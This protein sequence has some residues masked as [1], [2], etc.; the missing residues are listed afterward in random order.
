MEEKKLT[1]QESLEVIATMIN[2]TRE[3][4]FGNGNILL[5]WGLLV[6]ATA[7]LVWISLAATRMHVWHL[8]W[9]AIPA[10]GCPA[11]AVMS[12]N[13]LRKEGVKTYSD[14]IVSKLW[15]ITGISAIDIALVCLGFQLI[16]GICCWS[17]MLAFSL[18]LVSFAEIVQGLI[19][20]ENSLLFGG[21]TGLTIGIVT[22]C[23]FV[24]KIVLDANWYFPLYMLAFAA[25]MIVP[26]FV[27]NHKAKMDERA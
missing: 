26:G 7:A 25:M 22:V 8:L 15:T 20:R 16:G 3:R 10:I 23:C 5:M 12:R 11:T 2:R 24:G 19:I 27:L 6:I 13:R 21:F 17:A 4:Y 14:K 9:L 1:A 18:M